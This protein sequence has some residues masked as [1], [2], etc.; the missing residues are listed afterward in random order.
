MSTTGNNNN[1]KKGKDKVY[2]P[3]NKPRAKARPWYS[4]HADPKRLPHQ[5]VLSGGALIGGH[6]KS[7]GSGS[8]TETASFR[9][10]NFLTAA[11]QKV[12]N[13]SSPH[14]AKIDNTFRPKVVPFF[15]KVSNFRFLFLIF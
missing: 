3:N 7:Y 8:D 15:E 12:F 13:G 1:N 6:W 4:K 5:P 11:G 14:W 10:D 2:G 9:W